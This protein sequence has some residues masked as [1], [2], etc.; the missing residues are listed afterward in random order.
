MNRMDQ[1]FLRLKEQNRTALIPFLTVGDPD[2]ETTIDIIK[3]LEQAGADILELGVPY[4]DPLADGP[5]IQ[6]ASERALKSQISIR[7]CME[8][9]AKAREAG[10]QLPFVLFTY[11]NPVLQTGLDLFFDELVK[12]DISGMIIPDLPIEEAEEMRRRADAAGVHLV[13][14]VA[15]TS[16]ARIERIVNGARGFIYCVSSLG[17]TGERA[18]FFDGVERFIE[19][20]KSLTDIPVAVGFGISSHEQVERFSRICDGVVVGSAIVRQVEEAI[21]LLGNPDTR[22][23]GLL[24]IR[25]FVA[26]LKG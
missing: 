11:Y 13:P 16:N 26:Q 1:T 25:N 5:V 10:V 20:V 2:V 12:H 7:T 15:P 18:S 14:L 21:P 22:E 23:A 6:R 4:S 8:T 24:Q 17:V 9:A 19:T 3:E